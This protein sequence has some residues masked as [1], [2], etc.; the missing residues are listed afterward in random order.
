MAPTPTTDQPVAAIDIGTNSIRLLVARPTATGDALTTLLDESVTVRLGMGVEETGRLEPARLERAVAV[1]AEF[2]QLARRHHA[3]AVVLVATS[4]VRDAAN[5]AEL[6]HRIAATTGFEMEVIGGD[7][8]ARLTF[9]GATLGQPKTGA[10]LVADLGGGSLELIAARDGQV[11]HL[12]SLQLG[13]GRLTERH[14]HG[15]PPVTAAIAAI[16]RDATRLLAPVARAVGAI[17]RCIVTGG[18]AQSLPLITR[19]PD[20]AALTRRDLSTAVSAL[21]ATPADALAAVTDLDAAR[22]RT[23]AAGA[24]IIN[25]LLAALQLHEAYIASGGLREG[26]LLDRLPR[27]EASGYTGTGAGRSRRGAIDRRP[28]YSGGASDASSDSR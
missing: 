9:T 6:A 1:V 15:D 23:L 4:A 16:E 25:S 5:G 27:A 7:E 2:Q 8:E 24:T 3:G 28:L 19:Q 26:L 22:V 12:E 17:D 14:V 11:Y 21:L 18:T 13:S 20:K 10:L